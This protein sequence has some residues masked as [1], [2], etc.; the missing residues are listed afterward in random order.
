MSYLRNML[1][2]MAFGVLLLPGTVN[3]FNQQLDDYA[4]E[5]QQQTMFGNY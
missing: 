4:Y 5:P 1:E 2:K 3:T